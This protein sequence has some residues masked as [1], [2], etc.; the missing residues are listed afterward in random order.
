MAKPVL[1][2]NIDHK[3]LHILTGYGPQFGDNVMI[4]PTFPGEFRTLQAHYPIVFRK[5][6]DGVTFD[7]VALLGFQEGENLFLS[8]TG[9]DATDI[10]LSVQRLPFLIG[11]SGSELMMHIDLDSPRIAYAG[12]E[13]VFLPHGGNTEYLERM[14]SILRA[15]HEGVQA[16][17]PFVE[18][19][20]KYELL[21]S[22]VFDIE[23]DDGSQGRLAGF[24]II[25]EERLA[26]LDAAAVGALHK[27]GYLAAIY[28]LVA[29]LSQFRALIE[30]KNRRNAAGR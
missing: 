12:G 22:F 7:P 8:E 17:K 18:A 6:N 3:D 16:T 29:S 9:W 26:A 4:A 28:Y 13:Q 21:E 24:Y 5:A 20:L 2:N 10:P 15:L 14:N 23:L 19:L 30:R 27:D 25:N 1:L 11:V